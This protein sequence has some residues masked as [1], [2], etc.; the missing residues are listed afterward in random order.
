MDES[1]KE[2]IKKSIIEHGFLLEEEIK[3]LVKVQSNLR[4]EI[5]DF[6]KS[7]KEYNDS[8]NS[9]REKVQD[10]VNNS[11]RRNQQPTD[12]IY[13]KMRRGDSP[14]FL[15]FRTSIIKNKHPRDI[16]KNYKGTKDG[17][18]TPDSE[19]FDDG[20]NKIIDGIFNETLKLASNDKEFKE[21]IQLRN[22]IINS[23]K[24]LKEK[25]ESIIK[26]SQSE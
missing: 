14:V 15:N 21:F 19:I 11:L 2:K 23:T 16:L 10:L 24:Q 1:I 7:I 17:W 4:R 18:S 5:E 3:N 12:I 9:M 13:T 20:R 22:N 26:S 8:L 25:F 6:Y